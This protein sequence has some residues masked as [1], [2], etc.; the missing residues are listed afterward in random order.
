MQF[1]PAIVAL[2]ALHHAEEQG[3][4][5]DFQPIIS[6]AEETF[7]SDQGPAAKQAYEHLQQLGERLPDA[8]RFQEFL[9]HITWQQVTEEP[10]PK[11]FQKGFELC[12]RFLDRFGAAIE[13]TESYHR[14]L[15]IRQ[16]FKSGLGIQ[17]Q[18]VRDEYDEDSFHPP[19]PPATG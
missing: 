19:Q 8:Q 17:R 15:A 7:S 3:E 4:L 16:S 18:E 11:H 10:I 13:G 2:Q 14:I 5:G 1:D 12:N 6:E 9:I